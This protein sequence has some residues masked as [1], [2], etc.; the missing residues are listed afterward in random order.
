MQWAFLIALALGL[1]VWFMLRNPMTRFWRLAAHRPEEVLE[2]M[3]ADEA[4]KVFETGLPDDFRR[5]WPKDQWVGPFRLDLGQ[6]RRRVLVLGR[7]PGYKDSTARI[8]AELNSGV[9][10]D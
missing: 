9:K 8:L 3:R 4:W 1:N 5:T 6:P 10:S 7:N 2:M